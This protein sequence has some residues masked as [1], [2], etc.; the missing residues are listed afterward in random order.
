MQQSQIPT[1]ISTIFAQSAPGA[2]VTNPIPTTPPGGGFASWQQGWQ[3]VNFTP[4]SAGGIPPWG[5]D[6]NGLFQI[7]SAWL[8]WAQ[9][10]G[11]PIGYDSSFQATVGGYPNTAVVASA[12]TA[13][14][15]WRSIVDNNL[16]NPDTGGAGWVTF[17][18]AFQ[19][20]DLYY[21]TRGTYTAVVPSWAGLAAVYVWG[22]GGGGSGSNANIPATVGSSGGGGG[23][24]STI[25]LSV[26]FGRNLVVSV[27]AGGAGNVNGAQAGNGGNSS[28]TDNATFTIIGFGGNGGATGPGA[29]GPGSGGAV[30]L[31]GQGG[32]DLDGFAWPAVG[33]AIGGSA[34][35]GGGLGGQINSV[36]VGFVPTGPGGAGGA[37]FLVNIGQNGAD[38]GVRVVFY[39]S[40]IP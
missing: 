7:V 35:G 29:G 40:L 39:P 17:Q 28:V 14:L 36:N 20:Q 22:A 19:L 26:V 37:N 30:N 11:A 34:A 27:G 10:G 6:F 3:Q 12:V 25:G 32:Q 23:F 2:N 8:R 13:G 1:K 16:T 5:A 24:A 31:V 21:G 18:T 9:A 15:Y 33:S 38:G 4:V